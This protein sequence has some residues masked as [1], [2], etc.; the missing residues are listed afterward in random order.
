[1]V[2]AVKRHL[3]SLKINFGRAAGL[4]PGA[5]A[6][7]STFFKNCLLDNTKSQKR[8]SGFYLDTIAI[9]EGKLKFKNGYI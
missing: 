7:K 1:M 3:E 4:V 2:R 5:S 6:I 9:I 8:K